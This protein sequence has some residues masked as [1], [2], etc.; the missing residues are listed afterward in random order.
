LSWEIYRREHPIQHQVLI[1][2]GK[3]VAKHGTEFAFPM[4][5]LH[6]EGLA[7]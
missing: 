2:T 1:D 4:Q 6:V 7:G 3:V 5:M